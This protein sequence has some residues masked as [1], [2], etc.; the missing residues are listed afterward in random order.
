MI[1][2][3]PENLTHSG[4]PYILLFVFF[5][6]IPW[7]LEHATVHG[8]SV[9]EI[10]SVVEQTAPPYPEDVGDDK[11]RVVGAGNGGRLV[12]VVYLID[13]DGSIF[14]IH[15]RPFTDS[16]KRRHRRRLR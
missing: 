3:I 2:A 12:Q 10:E 11:H 6:W 7:N 8:A 4:L 1:P 14:V 13:D 5:R 15:A 16:E 9:A